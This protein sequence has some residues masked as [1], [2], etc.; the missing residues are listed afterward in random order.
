[1]FR[2]V[3]SHHAKL[4]EVYPNSQIAKHVQG[5]SDVNCKWSSRVCGSNELQSR[6][7]CVSNVLGKYQQSQIHGIPHGT[8]GD[9]HEETGSGNERVTGVDAE[10]PL[11]ASPSTSVD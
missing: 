5:F 9:T 1:M 6:E 2:D 10:I 8:S 4:Q 11:F 3:F 7:V